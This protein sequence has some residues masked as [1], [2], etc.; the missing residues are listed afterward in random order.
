MELPGLCFGGVGSLVEECIVNG[1][2][3]VYV[4][5][6]ERAKRKYYGPM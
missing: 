5:G 2:D 6:V 3:E 1:D 4:D